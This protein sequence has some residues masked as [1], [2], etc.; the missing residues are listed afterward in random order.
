MVAYTY[1]LYDARLKVRLE[2]GRLVNEL[3]SKLES[4]SINFLT[5]A[6]G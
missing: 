5:R 2:F 1:E 3:S 4:S 6:R